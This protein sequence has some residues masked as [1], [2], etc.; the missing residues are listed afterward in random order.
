MEY[1]LNLFRF[2]RNFINILKK[3]TKFY[4]I[5]IKIKLNFVLYKYLYPKGFIKDEMIDQNVLRICI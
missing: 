5:F 1:N 3:L 4:K 2:L